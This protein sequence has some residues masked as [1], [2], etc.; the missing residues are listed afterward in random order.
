MALGRYEMSYQK[1]FLNPEELQQIR[2]SVAAA[3]ALKNDNVNIIEPVG[4]DN[5]LAKIAEHITG[6][7]GQSVEYFRSFLFLASESTMVYDRAPQ[8]IPG[9]HKDAT[10]A[11]VDGDCFNA[12]L[13]LYNEAENSGVAVISAAKNPQI[14][15]KLEDLSYPLSIYTKQNDP[16]FF[17]MLEGKIGPD[18]DMVL[19]T[20]HNGVVV[21][22]NTNQL[23]ITRYE[24]P[25]AGDLA[26]FKQTEIHGGFH[27]SGVRIQLSLKFRAKDA[28]LNRTDSN[29]EYRLFTNI[30]R[31]FM[32]KSVP[33]TINEEFAEYQ[34]IRQIAF[35]DKGV[36]QHAT[37][38]LE[39]MK[40]LLD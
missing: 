28:G 40:A 27:Q 38:K 25:T 32:G 19:I 11:L 22:I 13:P 35:P 1:E 37:M 29:P 4:I 7:T 24:N 33:K 8:E 36:S 39:L 6:L 9:W 15:D 18:I 2:R 10:C 31:K 5:I 16:A 14:Y 20:P 34:V 21:P 3:V 30:S 17:N 26:I 23:N 12:W